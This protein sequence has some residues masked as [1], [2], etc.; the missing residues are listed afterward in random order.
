MTKI[1]SLYLICC[2]L[3]LILSSCSTLFDNNISITN[4]NDLV[5][6]GNELKLES[7][8]KIVKK[9]VVL[10]TM[11]PNVDPELNKAQN[12]LCSGVV[13]DDIG[14]IITNFHCIY[15]QNY[16]KL[17]YYDKD[18]WN[19]YDVNVI[20]LDPLADLALLKVIGKETPTPHLTFADNIAEIEEGTEVFTMGH[21]MGMAWSITKGII[22]S[23]ERYARHPFI[24][25]FQTDAA[26]NTGNSG[27]PLLNM[28][29]ELIGINALII[30][31]IKEN[32]GVG[33]AIRGDI[34]QKSFKSMV[35][36]GKVERPAVGVMIMPLDNPKTR[37]KL[38]K[39][40]PAIKPEN[41]PNT[42]GLYI[43]P[44]G[45]IPEGLKAHDTIIG[46]NDVMVNSGLQFSDEL[47]KYNIGD[48]ITLTIIRERRYLKVDVLLQ[49][50]PV[51]V[52]QLYRSPDQM[53]PAP[54]QPNK[55]K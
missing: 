35:E 52:E 30:S 38:V 25:T 39:D 11:S 23:N 22:S 14:H 29:G 31:R 44:D 17:Y 55:N 33:M 19:I 36:H 41:I 5:K 28:R 24:K 51:P 18:D 45:D 27:G 6:A 10:L 1:K 2:S 32:A 46:V 20:G 42:L 54:M 26:I 13:V 8:I 15:Q 34:V 12:A 43:R 37:N 3:L 21:P 47:I 40:F 16:I 9:S 53:A 48:I 7:I 4:N 49:V 50:F